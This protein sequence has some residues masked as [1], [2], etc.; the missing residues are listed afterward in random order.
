[1]SFIVLH[2][3]ADDDERILAALDFRHDVVWALVVA[4][5]DIF[6]GDELVDIDRVGALDLDRFELLGLDWDVAA[7]GQLVAAPL[8]VLVDY[9]A[10]FFVDHLLAEAVASPAVDL[11][12]TGLLSL[13]GRGVERDRASHE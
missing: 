1:L 5:V 2:G 10:G 12:E 3:V 7:V 13:R 6:L 9:I 8:L 11:M 4:L